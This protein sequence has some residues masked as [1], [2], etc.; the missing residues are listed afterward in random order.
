MFPEYFGYGL[1]TGVE[2]EWN[3]V[4]MSLRTR[5]PIW[6][7]PGVAGEGRRRA[8]PCVVPEA[9]RFS[10][11]PLSSTWRLVPQDVSL[12]GLRGRKWQPCLLGGSHSLQPVFGDL[13]SADVCHPAADVQ[14]KKRNGK[15]RSE[16][17]EARARRASSGFIL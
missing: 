14:D 15:E 16:P 11:R 5:G 6:R 13:A 12:P 3:W 7:F 4:A 10:I 2:G 8:G 17:A 9:A 1:K